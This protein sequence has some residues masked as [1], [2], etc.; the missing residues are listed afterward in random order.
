M[1]PGR[2]W[3]VGLSALGLGLLPLPTEAAQEIIVSYGFFERTIQIAELA[4]FAEGEGLSRQLQIYADL[5]ELS[6]AELEQIRQLLNQS[7]SF[8]SN[9]IEVDESVAI[10]QFLY[11]PQGEALLEVL[12]GVVQTPSRQSGFYAL[13]SALILAAADTPNGLSVLSFLEEFP[14][15]AIRVDVAR[16]LNIAA[17]VGRTVQSASQAINWVHQ[18]ASLAAAD[19]PES[20][21]L[22]ARQ[23]VWDAPPYGVEVSQVRVPQRQLSA[24][25][26]VPTAT[27]GWPALP[28]KVPVIVISHGLGDNRYSYDYLGRYLAQRGFIVAIPD[29]P[30]S[31]SDQIGNLIEGLSSNVVN[32]QEFIN[33]PQE[34]SAL[35][36]TL[37]LHFAN[38]AQ[39]RDRADLDRVGIIGQSFGGYT[40]LALGGASLNTGTLSTHCG[41]Q[42]VP[43]NPSLL[44]QCQARAIVSAPTLTDDRIQAVLAVNPIGSALFGPGGY[45]AIEVPTLVVAGVADTVAPALPEQ[46]Q[47]F[48]WLQTPDRYLV[49]IGNATHF[50]MIDADPN[51]A[52]IPLPAAVLGPNPRVAQNYLEV[53]SLGFFQTHLVGDDRYEAI[54]S[55]R[56][57]QETLSTP[58]LSPVSLV[59]TVSPTRVNQFL[60]NP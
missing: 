48:S 6:E 58:P 40:A 4:A 8:D 39:W 12:G 56:Y 29:H 26:Y 41:P 9:G 24:S 54:L 57:L 16:G 15:P 7:I 46:I 52:S 44:L 23:L 30:G 28:E 20:V 5:L 2:P 50:S 35:L 55:A 36:D 13:R 17:T 42:V 11:T 37:S 27:G 10:A 49:V 47:P 14:T 34:V 22:T 1:P 31:D 53:L 43:V 59:K 60:A 45:G 33:R 32:D 38:Q 25:L 19:E 21:V 18:E 51:S 3:W